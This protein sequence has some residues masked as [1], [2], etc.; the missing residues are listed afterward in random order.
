MWFESQVGYIIFLIT[1]VLVEIIENCYVALIKYKILHKNDK[2][3]THF[4]YIRFACDTIISIII[5]AECTYH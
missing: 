5:L 4:L 2:M 1:S 3:N